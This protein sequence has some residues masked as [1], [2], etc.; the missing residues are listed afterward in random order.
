MVMIGVVLFVENGSE[1]WS[2]VVWC[3]FL[4]AMVVVGCCDCDDYGD[5][6]GGGWRTITFCA[7]FQVCVFFTVSTACAQPPLSDQCSASV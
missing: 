1:W 2:L 7:V 6:G 5:G 4:M 3:C